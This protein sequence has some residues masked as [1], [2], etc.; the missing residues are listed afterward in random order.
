MNYF[1]YKIPSK[2]ALARTIIPTIYSD[3]K[4]QVQFLLNDTRHVSVT[5]DIWTSMNTDSFLTITAHFYPNDCIQLKTVVLCT[6]KLE[7]NHTGSYLAEMIFKEFN[8]WNIHNKVVAIVTDG[9][10]NMKAAVRIMN[11]QHIPCIAHK[12]NLIDRQAL[13]Q[14][15]DNTIIVGQP[16]DANDIKVL[17]NK[18]QGIVEFFKRSEIGKIMLSEKQ[19]Q[20]CVVE[21]LKVKQ[22]VCTRWNSTFFMIDRLVKLKEALTIVTISLKNAPSNLSTEEW[23]HS[24]ETIQQ[25]NS[26]A[27]SRGLSKVIPLLRGILK[28]YI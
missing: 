24:I 25:L 28:K 7:K 3:V 2:R 1:R 22:D 20:L 13:C 27:I 11:I 26:R 18:C 8:I 6:K 17:L 10:S 12:F 23:N 9:G 15:D 16:N 14:S 5:T 4:N 19:K 21:V